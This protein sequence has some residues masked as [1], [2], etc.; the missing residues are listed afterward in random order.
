MRIIGLISA[1]LVAALGIA[2][3]L[4]TGALLLRPIASG[5]DASTYAYDMGLRVMTLYF[6][7]SVLV[8]VAGIFMAYVIVKT[9]REGREASASDGSLP[10]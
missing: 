9:G 10:E 6:L 5:L 3:S 4:A 2:A 1:F 7:S 8:A